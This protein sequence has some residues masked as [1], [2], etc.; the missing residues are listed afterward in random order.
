MYISLFKSLVKAEQNP[1][2]KSSHLAKTESS[3]VIPFTMFF[4]ILGTTAAVLILIAST[5][6]HPTNQTELEPRAPQIPGVPASC[7]KET[8]VVGDGN[9]HQDK[10]H[11]QITVSSF[12]MSYRN[13][14]H[15]IRT[16]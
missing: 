5:K 8:Y 4:R 13:R 16:T 9:P 15:I 12:L 2:P 3:L 6:A 11:Q 14:I 7:S 10:Y 1:I